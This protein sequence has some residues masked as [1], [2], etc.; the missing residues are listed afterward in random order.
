M[1]LSDFDILKKINESNKTS[2]ETL[3]NEK[4]FSSSVVVQHFRDTNGYNRFIVKG[5][6]KIKSAILFDENNTC[7]FRE[8]LKEYRLQG[9]QSSLW[10]YAAVKLGNIKHSDNLTEQGKKLIK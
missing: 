4:I 9:L 5:F 10:L 8:T 6:K 7:I 3:I 1:I 2:F